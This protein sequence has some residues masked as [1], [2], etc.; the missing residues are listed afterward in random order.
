MPLPARRS[1][2]RAGAPR[3]GHHTAGLVPCS[4]G[5]GITL[6]AASRW[7]KAWPQLNR[8]GVW[9]PRPSHSSAAA[10]QQRGG[11][12]AAPLLV[13]PVGPTRVG[14]TTSTLLGW[15]RAAEGRA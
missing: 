13:K 11:H 6:D 3:H 9:A 5:E 15:C 10:G 2:A 14:A 12:N 1:P 8:K 7:A 4:R